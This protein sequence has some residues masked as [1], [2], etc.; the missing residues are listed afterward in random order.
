MERRGHDLVVAHRDD[1][2]TG[3]RQHLDIGPDALHPRRA[4]EHRVHR[5]V[6]AREFDV[7][8]L[9]VQTR[10]TVMPKQVILEQLYGTVEVPDQKII[11]VFVCKI[12]RKLRDAT[13]GNGVIDTVWGRGYIVRQDSRSPQRRVA[14]G[15]ERRHTAAS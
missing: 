4:D 12:R 2:V 10:G 11:D 7:L 9:L 5:R 15:G 6:K 3:A 1:V 14:A 13:G 8:E